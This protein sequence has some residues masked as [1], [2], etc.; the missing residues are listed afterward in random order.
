MQ[1]WI[2]DLGCKGISSQGVKRG[3]V[4]QN[5][6]HSQIT[7]LALA[8]KRNLVSEP[9]REISVTI[10]STWVC[11]VIMR[12]SGWLI[13]SEGWL[14]MRDGDDGENEHQPPLGQT[15]PGSSILGPVRLWQFDSP[16]LRGN[17]KISLSPSLPIAGSL[18]LPN[19]NR[20]LA[21]N[22]LL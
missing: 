11:S 15:W 17:Y 14:E 16:V 12:N 22:I 1:L 18:K 3:R 19:K 9:F 7:S 10:E 6:D 13:A 21:N 2:A 20:L 8:S 4:F 5:G